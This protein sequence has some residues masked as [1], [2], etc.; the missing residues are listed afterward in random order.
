MTREW[1]RTFI[2]W[3]QSPGRAEQERCENAL[4]V[5]RNAVSGHGTLGPMLRSGLIKVFAQGSYRNRVNVRAD[6]D[7]DVGV[8]YTGSF[9]ATYPDGYSEAWFRHQPAVYTYTQFKNDLEGALIEHLGPLKVQRGNK[10]IRVRETSYHLEADAAPF[11]E[12]KWYFDASKSPYPGVELRPDNAP[13]QRVI[14][15]PEALFPGWPKEHYENGRDKNDATRRRYRGM[16][17]ILK[18]IRNEMV[19]TGQRGTKAIPG[20]LVECLTWNTPHTRFEDDTWDARVQAVLEF[21]WS[22]T[23]RGADCGNLRE[24]DGIKYLFHGTQ[25]WSQERAHEFIDSAWDY[26]GVRRT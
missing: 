12:H 2:D 7:V 18:K 24:V 19:E 22:Q 9:F 8:L 15:Y 3:A 6:S 26:V 20:Y 1:E 5:I 21:L 25:S 16:V 10:S 11:F 14:N 23:R 17:R 13:H 4:K